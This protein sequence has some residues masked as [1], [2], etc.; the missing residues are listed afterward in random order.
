M[1]GNDLKILITG[2]LNTGATIGQINATLKGIEKKINKLSLK[3]DIG[4]DALKAINTFSNNVNKLQLKMDVHAHT[5][6]AE[7]EIKQ[8]TKSSAKY[9]AK[10][11]EEAKSQVRNAFG[12]D[13]IISTQAFKTGKGSLRSFIVDAKD[14]EGQI[15]RVN[16]ELRE[17]V[18]KDSDG[19]IISKEKKFV[20][21]WIQEMNM[22]EAEL[23]KLTQLQEKLRT[24]LQAGL[25][26]GKVDQGTYDKLLGN[27]NK[28]GNMDD[29]KSLQ[30]TNAI[31]KAQQE[32]NNSLTQTQ[33]KVTQSLKKMYD[34]GLINQKFFQNFN[35]VINSTKNVSEINK[36]QQAL[37]RVSE[38]AKNKNLQQSLLSQA[39]TL[40]GQGGT[41]RLDVSGVN[42]L[43]NSLKNIKPNATSASN[44]LQ[45]LQTQLKE[46][47]AN[48][49]V[50]H[51][52]TLTFGSALK[53]AFSG[54]ALWSVT[55]QLV[56]APVR[57]LQDMTQRL[58]EIDTQMTEIRRVMD[59]PDFKFVDMLQN[60]VNTVTNYLRN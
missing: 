2:T 15:K 60:A 39:N 27:I 47:A 29:L 5:K 26:K 43:I 37:Q 58:I 11:M 21:T 14:A 19:N 4:Q 50:A 20:S 42:N 51:A 34:Q 9:I 22:A 35:K 17:F 48:A 10:T 30:N 7:E 36:V 16:Y 23:K 12:D 57:A 1:A 54:F 25:I 45:R 53:Q 8:V 38:T 41:K 18:K 52:H 49:R 6:P 13:S 59:E 28:A 56:Y 32:A 33:N 24:Q 40:L 44:E 46:Y 31:L 3:V 55:A